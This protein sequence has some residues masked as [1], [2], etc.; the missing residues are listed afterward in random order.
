MSFRRT[1]LACAVTFACALAVFTLPRF[2]WNSLQGAVRPQPAPESVVSPS[3]VAPPVTQAAP[4]SVGQR[5]TG[6]FGIVLIL[7]IGMALPRTR[8]RIS[9]R[10]VA[11]GSGL[12]PALPL[13]LLR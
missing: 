13:V 6:L 10:S 5:L 2:A 12:P 9:W 4:R 1:V 7:W 3:I 11:G 8:R